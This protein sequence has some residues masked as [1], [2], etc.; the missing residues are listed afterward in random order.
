MPLWTP[1]MVD[2]ICIVC[3]I[4]SNDLYAFALGQLYGAAELQ[5]A[6]VPDGKIIVINNA[7]KFTT[8]M[9][10]Y[11]AFKSKK[12]NRRIADITMGGPKLFGGAKTHKYFALT[13]Y[14]SQFRGDDFETFKEMLDVLFDQLNYANLYATGKVNYLE[15]TKDS[16]SHPHHSFLPYRRYCTK[17]EIW[18]EPNGHLG[19]TYVGSK[20]SN[21]YFRIYDKTKQL[22][23]K[24]KPVIFGK[25]PHT[26]IEAVMRQ[27][28]ISPAELIT[29]PNPFLKLRI[30]D[31]NKIGKIDDADWQEFIALSRRVGVPGALGAYP[32]KRKAFMAS[33]NSAQASWW[34]PEL[35]WESLP[36]ALAK[37]AP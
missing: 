12:N 30:A 3:V 9:E 20:S 10:Y 25:L 21:L 32:K 14:P 23:D 31:L 22:V 5:K 28:K 2:R 6:Y 26:R 37:I 18:K 35:V 8:R 27:L 16:L 7:D 15:L 19:T 1:M 24:H 33:L 36:H 29:L 34:N 13:L 11:P 4:P 17:S